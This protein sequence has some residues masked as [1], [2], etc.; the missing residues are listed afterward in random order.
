MPES[1]LAPYL[2]ELHQRGKYLRSLCSG[3]RWVETDFVRI[4]ERKNGI[5]VGSYPMLYKGKSD[6]DLRQGSDANR[7]VSLTHRC[8]CLPDRT[9]RSANQGNRGGSGYLTRFVY[10]FTQLTK[11]SSGCFTGRQE[12]RWQG[13][14]IAEKVNDEGK[15]I[16]KCI[17]MLCN[18]KHLCEIMRFRPP[19][20][21]VGP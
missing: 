5:R 17:S 3:G 20:Y 21:H 18:N 11:P 15:D 19:V 8:A 9:G 16:S 2:T 4:I 10:R 1:S 7:D 14:R 13:R 6:A 12:A